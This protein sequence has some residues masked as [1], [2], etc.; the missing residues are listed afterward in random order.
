[1]NF[2]I[3]RIVLEGLAT[4]QEIETHWSIDDLADA[5]EVLDVKSAMEAAATTKRRGRNNG[6]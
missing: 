2:A 3:W 1:M 5:H 6:T 4:L